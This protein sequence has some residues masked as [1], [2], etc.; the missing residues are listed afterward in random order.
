M[1]NYHPPEYKK[2]WFHCIHCGVE[3]EQSWHNFYCWNRFHG[4]YVIHEPLEFSVCNHCK[5][6]SYWY[7][8]KLV[9]PQSALVPAA[10]QDMPAECVDDFNEARAIVDMSPK[11]AAALLRLALRKLLIEVGEDGCNIKANIANLIDNGLPAEVQQVLA[12][13]GMSD[14]SAKDPGEIVYSDTQDGAYHMFNIINFIVEDRISRPMQ[15][16]SLFAQLPES[17]KKAADRHD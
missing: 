4:G 3:A 6:C 10:H 5:K 17:V 7:D 8:G 9:V 13:C 1:Q 15:I 12:S 2:Q 14:S 16:E 11:A